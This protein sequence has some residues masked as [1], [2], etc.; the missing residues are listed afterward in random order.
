MQLTLNSGP[1]KNAGIFIGS[2]VFHDLNNFLGNLSSATSSI[3]ILTEPKIRI[4]CLGPL[5]ALVPDLYNAEVLEVQG[6][7]KSKSLESAETL[8]NTL[9]AKGASRNSLLINLGGGVVTDLG[10]FV[11]STFKRGIPFIHIPTSLLGM[12]DAAIGGKTGV[13]LGDVKNQ[14]GTFHDPEAIFIHTGFLRTLDPDEQR[15]GFA[16][17]IKIALAADSGLWKRLLSIPLKDLMNNTADES[18]WEDLISASVA[19]KYRIVEQDFRE[20]NIREI[21]NFGHTMGHAFES[22]SMQK[23]GKPLS[24]GHAIALGMICESYLS[25]LKTGL[26]RKLRDDIIRMIF[27]EYSYFPLQKED[28]D[29]MMDFMG[30]DKKRRGS[31]IRFTLLRE[32][33]T[34]IPGVTCSPEEIASSF[35]FYSTLES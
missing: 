4:C 32:P 22:L 13:N 33:G 12:V 21:L 24:H 19:L 31:G 20:Q 25:S 7:E 3:F 18:A 16:E 10:G 23:N 26:D 5:T 30:H 35:D 2:S 11:A 34:A 29:F 15:S 14:V 28:R 1:G 8:W 6:G 27:P 9:A 17:I